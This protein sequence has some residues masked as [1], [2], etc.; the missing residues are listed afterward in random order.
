MN[1]HGRHA[2]HVTWTPGL[3]E[4]TFLPSAQGSSIWNFVTTGP[5]AFEEMFETVIPWESSVKQWPWPLDFTK[6]VLDKSNYQF[7]GQSLQNVPWNCMYRVHTEG[8][9]QISLTFPWHFP[10]TNSNFPDENDRRSAKHIFAKV[11]I[12]YE[13]IALIPV[14]W[15]YFMFYKDISPSKNKRQLRRQRA[16]N[17]SVFFQTEE[18]GSCQNSSAW[19]KQ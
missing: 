8:K 5:V 1:R 12:Y 2:G 7:L 9:K 13:T 17:P 4:Q 6:H 14:I 18:F 10:D 3:F 19:P 16:P 11:V 15:E